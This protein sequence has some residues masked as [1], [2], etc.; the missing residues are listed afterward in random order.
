MQ[1]EGYYDDLPGDVTVE[2]FSSG[3]SVVTALAKGDID[4]AIIQEP[5]VTIIGRAPRFHEL[6]HDRHAH[7]FVDCVTF[8]RDEFTA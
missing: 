6:A 4:T 2:R 3:P 8:V 1:Q 5:F 7:E